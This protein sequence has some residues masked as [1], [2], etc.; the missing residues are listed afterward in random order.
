MKMIPWFAFPFQPFL[1]QQS[2]LPGQP[3]C[4]QYNQYFCAV[5]AI[6]KLVY[7]LLLTYRS[8]DGGRWCTL[9]R[10][11]MEKLS[12]KKI[13]SFSPYSHY[14]C[15]CVGGIFSLF[16]FYIYPCEI[17]P[18]LGES[19]WFA[20][21]QQLPLWGQCLQKLNFVLW[22]MFFCCAR[23]VEGTHFSALVGEGNFI[24]DAHHDASPTKYFIFVIFIF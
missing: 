15:Q 2:H 1:C 21:I 3:I 23:L 9:T 10:T 6:Y 22:T 19:N 16:S 24:T 13:L 8:F 4:I 11:Q 17:C 18:C 5:N 14:R 12:K 20:W 7:L